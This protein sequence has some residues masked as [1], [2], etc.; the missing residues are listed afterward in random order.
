MGKRVGLHHQ[1]SAVLMKPAAAIA[2]ADIY[3]I[4]GAVMLCGPVTVLDL[5]FGGIDQHD[6]AG[7]Q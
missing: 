6:A 1:P 4:H 5:V 7:A 2:G 3:K